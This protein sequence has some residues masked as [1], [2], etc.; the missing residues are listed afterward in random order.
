MGKKQGCW[1]CQEII[2]TQV[3]IFNL[4]FCVALAALACVIAVADFYMPNSFIH[5]VVVTSFD[6]FVGDVPQEQYCRFTSNVT[7]SQG[8][9]SVC[10]CLLRSNITVQTCQEIEGSVPVYTLGYAGSVAGRQYVLC[11]VLLIASSCLTSLTRLKAYPNHIRILRSFIPIV[12]FLLNGAVL[13]VSFNTW[14]GDLDGFESSSLHSARMQNT[15]T[16]HTIRFLFAFQIFGFFLNVPHWLEDVP[17]LTS[18]KYPLINVTEDVSYYKT[19]GEKKKFEDKN[20]YPDE[21]KLILHKSLLDVRDEYFRVGFWQSVSEDITFTTGC[22]LFVVVFSAS[23]GVHDDSTLFMDMSCVLVIGILQ[24]MSHV[25]MLVKEYIFQD[26]DDL[27]IGEYDIKA[28]EE[29]ERA[30]C[31][32]I[33]GTRLMIHA[34]VFSIFVFYC[35]RTAPSTFNLN[36]ITSMYQVARFSVVFFMWICNT[37]YDIFFEVIHVIKHFTVIAPGFNGNPY[38]EKEDQTEEFLQYHAQYRGPYI[39]RVMV[40]LPLLC[41]FC[42]GV[43]FMQTYQPNLDLDPRLT[44]G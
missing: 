19:N 5:R 16:C 27:M 32:Y 38:N 14:Y 1:S 8:P 4:L 25:L 40:V 31:N 10:S 28:T 43:F 34:F 15:W 2:D 41:V 22:M 33:G 35:N 7:A 42:A 23:G 39:W 44:L 12:C 20:K 29:Y 37:C 9:D 11:A 36:D 17:Y 24:H 3:K 21:Y 13:Y 30:I 26:S 6:K 18:W